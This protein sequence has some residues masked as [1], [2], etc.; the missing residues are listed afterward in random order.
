MLGNP[1]RN[2]ANEDAN[3]ISVHILK[4]IWHW[5]KEKNRFSIQETFNSIFK[6]AYYVQK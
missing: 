2:T 4:D 3:L 5:Q 6:P 1:E